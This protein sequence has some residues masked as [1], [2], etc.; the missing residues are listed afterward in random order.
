L[1]PDPYSGSYDFTNPQSLNRY[2]YV[3]NN[4][5]SFTDRFGLQCQSS[6]QDDVGDDDGNDGGCGDGTDS[7]G[8]PGGG[9]YGPPPSGF[10]WDSS[11]GCYDYW[12]ASTQSLSGCVGGGSLLIG[13]TGGIGGGI[14]GGGVKGLFHELICSVPGVVGQIAQALGRTVGF[15]FGGSADAGAFSQGFA[16]SFGVQIVSDA[17]KNLGIVG[18]FGA[19]MPF[20][21]VVVGAG[22][23]GG[24]Q[25]SVSN[26][27]NISQLSGPVVDASVGGGNGLG[28]T[29]DVSAGLNTNAQGQATGASGV[30]TGTVTGPF[31][32][33][34]LGAAGMLTQTGVISTS[35]KDVW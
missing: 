4:P 20:G 23:T 30:L 6:D 28:A 9:G 35:Y 18:T 15:G 14:G 26:A 7:G 33:G 34:G 13:A 24:P 1:S 5:L 12:D 16:I 19:V 32:V 25:A 27:Q 17:Q 22:A 10:Q 8:G 3:L 29:V 31:S 11:N 21:G 2:S